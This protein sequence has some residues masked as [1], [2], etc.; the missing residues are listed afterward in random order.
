MRCGCG[1][2]V[3]LWRVFEFVGARLG[4]FSHDDACDAMRVWV[5][6]VLMI[7]TARVCVCACACVRVCLRVCVCV[8]MG[9][10]LWGGYG[11]QSDAAEA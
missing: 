1:V 6:A 2:E 8:I 4:N 9:L 10:S 3:C 7:L 5:C 11:H